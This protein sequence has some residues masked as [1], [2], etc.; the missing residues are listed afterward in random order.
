MTGIAGAGYHESMRR[1][2]VLAL[3]LAFAAG[4]PAFADAP[5]GK[6]KPARKAAAKQK[7]ATAKT[8]TITGTV[9]VSGKIRKVKKAFNPYADVYGGYPEKPKDPPPSHLCVYL[10]EVPGSWPAPAA[11]AV[12]DQRDREFSTDI[13]PVLAGTAVDFTNHDT[14]FHNI[15]SYSKPNE[16]DLG[17]RAGGETVSRVFD[18]LPA[19]GIGV[20]AANCEIH[21]NMKATILVMRNPFYAVLPEAGGPFTLA[22]VPAG[23]YRLTAWHPSL[24]PQPASVTVPAGGTASATL[25][26]RGEE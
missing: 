9:T 26:L 18:K 17:R 2:P 23:S 16:F 25:A 8:G 22:G 24:V 7:T 11:H 6:K 12:L 19:K 5:A 10:E 4:L 1:L 14:I 20:V 3:V 15:F 21:S 13:L